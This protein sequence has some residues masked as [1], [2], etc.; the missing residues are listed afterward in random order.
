MAIGDSGYGGFSSQHFLSF[1]LNFSFKGGGLSHDFRRGWC[2]PIKVVDSKFMV[3]TDAFG[4]DAA[5]VGIE[6]LR[7]RLEKGL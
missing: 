3:I 5:Q 1:W 4:Q 2:A 7:H 6:L